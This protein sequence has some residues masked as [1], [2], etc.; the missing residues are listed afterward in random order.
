MSRLQ[1]RDV[2]MGVSG[3]AMAGLVGCSD[4]ADKATGADQPTATGSSGS[5]A[6][7][8][9]ASGG[10]SSQPSSTSSEKVAEPGHLTTKQAVHPRLA[11]EG[12]KG[13]FFCGPHLLMLMY[14]RTAPE[15][16]MFT[17]Q[18]LG[19]APM[20]AADGEEFVIIDS[21][22]GTYL[23]R[24]KQYF[25]TLTLLVGDK[26]RDLTSAI[27]PYDEFSQQWLAMVIS[28]PKGAPVKLQIRDAGKTAT[29]DVRTMKPAQDADTQLMLTAANHTKFSFSP[30]KPEYRGG[31]TDGK[32]VELIQVGFEFRP[33]K[34]FTTPWLPSRGWAKP[35]RTFVSI[36]Y[37]AQIKQKWN[38]DW[39][40]EATFDTG[41]SKTTG[42]G[43]LKRM[44]Y[45]DV[46]MLMYG[47]QLVFE[48]PVDVTSGT[49][50][51]SWPKTFKVKYGNGETR[52]WP[53]RGTAPM[54]T[55]VTIARK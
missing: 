20:K 40:V 3:L 31:W 50:T 14:Q 15:I 46:N 33:D 4:E 44:D 18:Q 30:A 22:T 39:V 48:A 54:T 32:N 53:N 29:F 13:G 27:P 16:D 24:S 35:G 6:P 51:M 28:V 47:R 23:K 36:N 10:A 11:T 41:K 21:R 5:G 25:A 55:K 8:A 17:A 34:C 1:R 42:T 37:S 12:T 7:S 19:M 49:L 52:T 26:K 9:S 38:T 43:T 2:L 45:A